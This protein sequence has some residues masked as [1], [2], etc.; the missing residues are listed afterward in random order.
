MDSI[1]DYDSLDPG[2][3]PGWG[4]SFKIKFL[5][6]IYMSDK[7]RNYQKLYRKYKGKYLNLKNKDIQIGGGIT[8]RDLLQKWSDK[9][10]YNIEFPDYSFAIK[11]YPFTGNDLDTVVKY[12]IFREDGLS[13]KQDYSSFEEKFPKDKKCKVISFKNLSGNTTLIVPCP[14]VGKN[15]AHIKLFDK[16]AT[17][18]KKLELWKKVAEEINNIIE[19]NKDQEIYLNTHGYGVPYLHVRIDPTPKYGYEFLKQN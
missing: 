4:D 8:W 2:S 9:K 12:E 14:D 5:S 3:I 11:F 10:K 1:K 13:K 18:S 6:N 15:Y 7:N 19:N 17:N 16:N